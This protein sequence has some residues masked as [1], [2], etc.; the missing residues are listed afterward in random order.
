MLIMLIPALHIMPPWLFIGVVD[1]WKL[2]IWREG[3]V[4]SN[5]L[6]TVLN[7]V[8]IGCLLQKLLW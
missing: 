7:F 3:T 6:T 1:N 5:N 4:F 2:M 8:E